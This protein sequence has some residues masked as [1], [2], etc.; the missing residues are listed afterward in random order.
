MR[1]NPSVSFADASLY[2]REAFPLRRGFLPQSAQSADSPL[3]VEEAFPLQREWA[4]EGIGPYKF[5]FRNLQIS[6]IVEYYPFNVCFAF[7]S[8][9][10]SA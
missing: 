9:S 3:L 6:C 5:Y 4:D 10:R 7:H 2:T 1:Y 8:A